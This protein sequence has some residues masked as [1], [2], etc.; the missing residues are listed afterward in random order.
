MIKSERIHNTTLHSCIIGMVLAHITQ[1]ICPALRESSQ[2]DGRCAVGL[3]ISR[4]IPHNFRINCRISIPLKGT[5]DS[6]TTYPRPEARRLAQNIVFIGKTDNG[7][8]G[9]GS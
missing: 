2:G 9:V 5:G 4:P 6:R 8:I 3:G 7:A 1:I